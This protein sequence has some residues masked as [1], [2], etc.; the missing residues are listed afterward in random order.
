MLRSLYACDPEQVVDARGE[1]GW[2]EEIKR[3]LLPSEDVQRRRP[4]WEALS[5]LF[6]GT[7]LSEAVLRYI[8]RVVTAS[9]YTDAEVEQIL[10]GE[11]FPVCIWNMRQ[12]AGEWAGID[13][14]RLQQCILANSRKFWQ[15]MAFVPG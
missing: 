9:G 5:D 6:L 2:R 15:R 7:E 3:M 1:P 12:V 14:D 10:Y 4:V 13:I 8:A 11:V